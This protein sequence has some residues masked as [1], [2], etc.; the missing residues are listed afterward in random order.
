[1]NKTRIA[2]LGTIADLHKQLTGYDLDALSRI[3]A[4]A[5]PDLLGV[6]I[7]RDEFERGDLNRAPVEVREAIIPLARGSDMVVVP[8]GA[9][10]HEEL[11]P[12]NEGTAT[13]LIRGLDG[14]LAGVQQ[15]ANDARRMNSALVEHTCGLICH[16]EEHICGEH[17]RQMW[18]VTNEKMLSNIVAMAHRDP[19]TR[20]LVAVQ[21][22]RKHWLEPKLR[23]V[24]EID[25]VNYWNL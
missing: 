12:S 16:L 20:I 6:E 11:R 24:L 14:I 25:V 17:G 18:E 23:Q 13:G 8:I 19:R 7:E 2:L 3:I 22:R 15:A 21:C 9:G 1:M 5:Q 10:S 4:K